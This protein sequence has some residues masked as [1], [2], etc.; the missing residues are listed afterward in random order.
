MRLE[1]PE[2]SNTRASFSVSA[3]SRTPAN[4]AYIDLLKAQWILHTI[5]LR[6]DNR[7]SLMTDENRK[8]FH[9][10][11]D[12]S[13]VLMPSRQRLNIQQG[14]RDEFSEFEPVDEPDKDALL[15]QNYNIWEFL[16]PEEETFD[17][18]DLLPGLENDRWIAVE[19]NDAGEEDETVIFRTFVNAAIGG[20][21]SRVRSKGAPYMLLLSTKEGESEPKVTI[22]NQSGTLGLTR[23]LT[24][25]DL[26]EP[27]VADSPFSES[28]RMAESI[29]LNFGRMNV[30]VAFTNEADLNTF[31]RI[32]RAYFNA[33][34]RREPRQLT[35]KATETLLFKSSVEVY[36][37]LKASTMKPMSPRRQFQSCD[38]RVLETTTKEAWRTTR[39]LVISSSAAEKKPWCSEMFLP[40]SRVQIN[41]EGLARQAIVKWSDCTHEKSERTDGAYNK[42]YDYVY[43]DSNPNICLSLLFRNQADAADFES[44]ILKLSYP[45]VFSW[46]TGADTRNVYN[47]SDTEPNAR[48]YKALMVS[49]TRF[50]WK[51]CEL[52]YMYRD[53]DYC[54]HRAAL[55][56]R[57]PQVYYT[58]YIS[59]H[60]DKLYQAPPDHLPHFS[61]CEKRVGNVLLD[62][63]DESV[64]Q[65]FMSSL[66]SGHQLIFSRRVHFIT[67][68]APSRFKSTKS[69]KGNAEVQLWQ[70]ANS[71]R[72]LSRWG[73]IVED[74]WLSMAVPRGILEPGKDSNR[75]ILPDMEYDRGRKIDMSN[76][77]ARDPREK[78]DVNKKGPVTIAFECVRGEL[79]VY[80][81]G[82]LLLVNPNPTFRRS[83]RIRSRARRPGTS[84]ADISE[85]VG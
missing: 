64:A 15:D 3:K 30:A 23:D 10:L 58:N 60:V 43:D 78:K 12:V 73:D 24:M 52:F 49:H 61:H 67:T 66:T 14:I 29:P 28:A 38:L 81:R 57:F 77:V 54:Y 36:E 20:K 56:V 16:Q 25:D 17:D 50:D 33:V 6:D 45:S 51:Y 2:L 5:I 83:R 47:V 69:N 85:R 31:M 9:T 21:R 62:F 1:K 80:N 8:L 59:T 74:K 53:I 48:N 22:C 70:K 55:R 7:S 75:A 84:A 46:T 82:V 19:Q 11:S 18:D 39:R 63:D 40:L 27:S 71:V 68:K 32:P 44:T 76:L 4:Q 13:V 79:R 37:Q 26:Q 65:A 34:R 72:L 41:R 42:I 35:E